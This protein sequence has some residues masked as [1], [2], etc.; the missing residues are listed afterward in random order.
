M[1]RRAVAPAGR[2]LPPPDFVGPGIESLWA[3]VCSEA[4]NLQHISERDSKQ[5]LYGI[6]LVF[7]AAHEERVVAPLCQGRSQ[8]GSTPSN[9]V[10]EERCGHTVEMIELRKRS[11]HVLTL[12]P[13][14]AT[15]G[16]ADEKPLADP[17]IGGRCQPLNTAHEKKADPFGADFDSIPVR[18]YPLDQ[19]SALAVVEVGESETATPLQLSE[20][21]VNGPSVAPWQLSVFPRL[22]ARGVGHLAQVRFPHPPNR[23]GV[24]AALR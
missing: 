20:H 1:V 10:V 3:F 15:T 17:R 4:I 13:M 5:S 18:M 11:Q 23:P 7:G 9:R 21:H 24:D 12:D 16:Q 22:G 2:T 8:T 14:A 19:T 6:D